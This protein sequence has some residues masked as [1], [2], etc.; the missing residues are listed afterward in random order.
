MIKYYLHKA[1]SLSL[2]FP[3][4]LYRYKMAMEQKFQKLPASVIPKHYNIHL[5][6]DLEKFKFTG[7]INID[8]EIKEATD[9]ITLNS[10]NLNFHSVKLLSNHAEH[11][12]VKTEFI[13]DEEKVILNFD[14]LL[15]QGN[16]N[17]YIEY[18]GNL[19][20][21]MR[22]FYR[23]KYTDD[24]GQQFYSAVTQLAP[25]DARRCFPC[26][27]EP[28]L[29]A[30]FDIELTSNK[31]TTLS[32]TSV[33]KSIPSENSTKYTFASTPKM[34]TYL[35]AFVVGDFEYVEKETDGVLIRVYTPLKKKHL[36]EFALDVATKVLH[37]YK[38]YFKIAYPLPKLDLVA[39]AGLSYGA[40]E[41]WGLITYREQRLLI[42]PDNSSTATKQDVTFVVAHELAHQWFG[43]LV[44]MKW[45]TDLWLNEGYAT[46]T[47]FL[48]TSHLY[49]EY[50]I[51]SQFVNT[52]FLAALELDGLKN[53][54]PIEVPVDN[55]SEINQIFDAI[56]YNKGASVIRMLHQFIG[57][58]KFREGMC[59]YLSKHQYGNTSTEDLWSALEEASK[60]PVA[61]IMSTWTKQLGFPLIKVETHDVENGVNIKLSQ[62]KYNS[63]GS[64]STEKH[65]WMV[66][67]SISTSQNPE[68]HENLLLTNE[69]IEKTIT[70]LKPTDWIKINPG[71]VGFYRTLYT[72]EMLDKFA[73]DIRNRRMPP[74]DRLGLLEDIYALVKAGYMKTDALL[75]FLQN[76]KQ[77]TNSNVWISIV[78]ILSKLQTLLDYSECSKGFRCYQK[79]L[80]KGI[81]ESIG[82]EPRDNDSQIDSLLR[83]K[84]LAHM[85]SI[86][87]EEV[88]KEARR[89]FERHVNGEKILPADLRVACYKIVISSG[90]KED[91]E[92]LFRLYKTSDL[93][94]EKLRI[95]SGLGATEQAELIA[96]LLQFSLS[97]HVKIQDGVL[98]LI[99]ASQTAAGRELTWEFIKDNW[100]TIAKKFTA[101]SLLQNLIK[102]V[103][104][105]FAS[106]R[107]LGELEE[108]FG[109]TSNCWIDKAVQQVLENVGISSAWLR[110]DAEIIKHYFS[111]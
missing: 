70:G 2:Q 101:G 10:L 12:P 77:E 21:N 38:E 39:V 81:Y 19:E 14:K 18:E 17:L 22:G 61:R 16:Y 13:V 91:F 74:L 45:W 106:E 109:K 99:A 35:V 62:T 80:L 26:W 52:Y 54:H 49:P 75:D 50:D 41:N 48:V 103:A 85:S 111:S 27:D 53:S 25:A 32:N 30:T 51:W 9:K 89:R 96:D 87:D 63:D 36:G 5:L 6:P 98:V 4:K 72:N 60:Q 46:F 110:R 43:N 97:D 100:E 58:E 84:L 44:T 37:Y 90:S 94:E 47:Q 65:I 40:M 66:P 82:W 95:V 73:V 20:D 57:E 64:Q 108:F 88:T 24:K 7:K 105:K 92:S 104:G 34:S 8:I 67:I 55:P 69:S 83:G 71:V 59:L 15:T 33:I 56:T 42:D 93:N 11:K 68:V 86:R 28:A 3:N 102:E 78:T 29:K 23:T 1:L 79:R 31:R 107:K 76:Y